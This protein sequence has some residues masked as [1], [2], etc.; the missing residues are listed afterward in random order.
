MIDWDELIRREGPAVW[1]TAYRLVR[2]QADA[3]ECLQETFL[4]ALE[5]SDR[6][7][8]LDWPALLQRLA[9]SR[10]V[11]RLRK[12]L[13]QRRHEEIADLTLAEGA[14]INPSQYA[15]SLELGSAL[16][17]A[18][19]QLPTRQVEVFCLH[20]LQDWSYQQ[21]AH[22]FG[23]STSAVGVILHRTRQKL[24]ALLKMQNRLSSTLKERRI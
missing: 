21:I 23:T 17:S 24:Q 2:N 22:Q 7:P 14:P 9:T 8:I 4:S 18:L 12:K 15:E 3:D 5:A 20:E 13:R 19:A 10:A 6:Q 16:R 11:D 1:W